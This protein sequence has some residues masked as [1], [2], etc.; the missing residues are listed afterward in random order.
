MHHGLM[1]FLS[2][3]RANEL[4]REIEVIPIVKTLFV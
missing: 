3:E 1:K 4:D 2:S